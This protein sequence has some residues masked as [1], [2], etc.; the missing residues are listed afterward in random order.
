MSSSIKAP[1][2][3]GSKSD[4]LSVEWRTMPWLRRPRGRKIASV[5]VVRLV[6][7]GI[8]AAASV[9]FPGTEG[10]TAA[11]PLVTSAT[12][13]PLD[14]SALSAGK[15][16]VWF[17]A[18][19][20]TS[21]RI[22]SVVDAFHQDFPQFMLEERTVSPAS[23][24]ADW[25]AESGE[26]MPDI[27]FIDNYA[28]LRP[29]S[30][31]NAVWQ[32][33]GHDRFRLNG[34]WV[35]SK[36]TA[37]IEAAR[38]FIRWLAVSPHWRAQPVRNAGL[39]VHE[40]KA[41][42]A[43]A[44]AAAM[45]MR[46]ADR[47][48]LETL[49][50]ADAA[51]AYDDLSYEGLEIISVK[52]VETFGN[53]RLAFS[54]V[55]M[56]GASDR[57][58]GMRYMS[59]IFRKRG[60]EWFIL[61]LD[62]NAILA[63]AESLFRRFDQL[64]SDDSAQTSPPKPEL[65]EPAENGE[66]PLPPSRK[67]TL[68]WAVS[69]S[70]PLSFLIEMQM[71]GVHPTAPP[72]LNPRDL[73]DSYLTVSPVQSGQQS[74]R[75]EAPFG[76]NTQPYRVRVWAMNSAGMTTLSDWREMYFKATQSGAPP[77]GPIERHV[78]RVGGDYSDFA[79]Q[80]SEACW[81][82]CLSDDKC[83]AFA[84]NNEAKHCWLKDQ[85]TAPSISF[86]TDSA[87][88]FP[89]AGAAMGPID[90]RVDRVGGDYR[91]LALQS[92]QACWQLCLS[93]AKC[94][95]FAFNNEV[96]HC[97]LKDRVPP[98]SMSY[99]VDSAVK[100][101]SVGPSVPNRSN[102]GMTDRPIQ[103]P[104]P[105]SSGSTVEFGTDRYGNDYRIFNVAPENFNACLA[106]C[107]ADAHCQAWSYESSN[108]QRSNG[109]CWLKNPA[110]AAVAKQ[111]TTSGVMPARL[112]SSGDDALHRGEEAFQAR[113]YLEASLWYLRAAGLGNAQAEQNLGFLYYN[114]FGVQQDY[115]QAA[116]WYKKAADQGLPVGESS[117]GW[118]YQNGLGVPRDYAEALR[119]NG[120][121]AEKGDM[122]GEQ[123]LG[124]LYLF[125]LGVP[126]DPA[127]ARRLFGLAAAQGSSEAKALLT[128]SGAVIDQASPEP[129]MTTSVNS[130]GTFVNPTY[131]GYRLDWCRIF[132]TDCGAPAA[133][134][135][136][137]AQGFGRL[138]AFKFQPRS[139]VETMTIGQNSVC[140]PQWHGCDSFEFVRCR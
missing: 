27:A 74:Y 97:W 11:Q 49:F 139:G 125:G 4:R 131:N 65:T 43:K 138:V 104:A 72:P 115:S 111:I 13:D 24:V 89:S 18:A 7:A 84:F 106:A 88:K 32:N 45:S 31:Q 93:D 37:H 64:I 70:P 110:P 6:F 77:T 23:F 103:T 19:P 99:A 8:L 81:Q 55:E 48:S 63:N 137:K 68:A 57:I 135:F 66:L 129:P 14:F 28:Q 22:Q 29:L 101:D 113:D 12:A 53:S 120:K 134:A 96:N 87:V 118:M 82:R 102:L 78:D 79:L 44:I 20:Y 36:R 116:I 67:P 39:P 34:W 16:N 5:T 1:F 17:A 127:E 98:T 60:D 132:E 94:R 80:S 123:N 100:A 41:I 71:N 21:D 124:R 85:V 50:D 128:T 47:S 52:P 59:F 95:A 46:S 133:D 114:G 69:A 126:R 92:T 40:T 105:S 108:A 117:I 130:S 76:V 33:W 42:E 109:V 30:Q 73:S 15:L 10:K 122:N 91:D 3:V 140:D 56:A 25:N 75:I 54:I 121:A 112:G 107:Q 9:S 35:I 136:C 26:A 86:A 90:H 2:A 83:Q 58:Y 61:K 38:A 62:R 51:R 119:W